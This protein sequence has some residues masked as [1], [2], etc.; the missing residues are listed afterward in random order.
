MGPVNEAVIGMMAGAGNGVVSLVFTEKDDGT[1]KKGASMMTISA[2]HRESL[3]KLMAN[4]H[5]THPHFVRCIIPNE[6]KKSGHI[7]APLA[8]H[9]LNCNGVLEGIRICMLGLPNKVPHADFMTRYSIVA[10]KIFADMAG[11][12]KE[13]AQKSLVEAGMDPDSFRC[14][15]TK[16]MFRAGMLSKLE[17]IREGALSK[18][19]V[20]MQ[21]QARRVLVH[22]TYQAK[23]AE[24]KGISAIQRN[25][26]LYYNCRDWVWYQ[27]YT[28]IKGEIGV[29]KKKLAEEE[30][31]RQM[32]E[33][34][35]KFQAILDQ[36]AA[37]REAAAATHA[38]LKAKI[39]A[40]KAEIEYLA[41]TAGE[42]AAAILAAEEAAAAAAAS[43]DDRIAWVNG[44][45]ASLKTSLAST[46]A[47]LT[48]GRD[49]VK[50]ELAAAKDK[51]ATTA[52]GYE[53]LKNKAV[54]LTA[55]TTAMKGNIAVIAD[56]IANLDKKATSALVE[57]RELWSTI[58]V[59][60]FQNAN[61]S[62][63]LRL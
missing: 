40:T 33:G 51:L 25:I 7:D 13:C 3:M 46:K 52:G 56:A 44:E 2:A 63:F 50:A 21:C 53:K 22:V 24:K 10:P 20:K 41:S 61:H 43:L 27:F 17:E 15:R 5:S 18:I 57:K 37:E 12:P 16:I 36:A 6:I 58:S 8:M 35:A 48:K 30:R 60:K 59:C 19:I 1:K 34:L 42:Q 38:E 4:L 62:T 28:M 29:L 45:R 11:D 14:G 32:A 49:D 9:Q 55:E 31:R 39:V 23:I 47:T 26:R 54:A